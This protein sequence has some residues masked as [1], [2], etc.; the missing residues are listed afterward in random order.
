MHA[1]TKGFDF[2]QAV[3]KGTLSIVLQ[4]VMQAAERADCSF[5][6]LDIG[7]RERQPFIF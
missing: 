5:I 2:S 4:E 3:V 6:R 7:L 1:K